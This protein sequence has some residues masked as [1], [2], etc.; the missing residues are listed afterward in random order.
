MNYISL[1]PLIILVMI[2]QIIHSVS[3]KCKDKC[4]V[5][6]SYA[7]TGALTWMCFLVIRRLA[8]GVNIFSNSDPSQTMLESLVGGILWGVFFVVRDVVKKSRSSNEKHIFK[9]N[10][11]N[12]VY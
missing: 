8:L 1:L 12:F 3:S 5:Q 4:K 2:I 9:W 10:G 7:V 6:L 11:I